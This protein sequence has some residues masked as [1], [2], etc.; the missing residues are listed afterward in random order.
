RGQRPHGTSARVLS[1]WEPVIVH[2][3][4]A[5]DPSRGPGQRIDSLVHGVVPMTTLPSRVTGTK[6]AAFCRWVFDLLGAQPGDTLHDLYP[7]SGAVTRAWI[8]YTHPPPQPA[9]TASEPPL[10]DA[11][12]RTRA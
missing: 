4:R 11:S 2:G 8:T 9:D 1:A 3:G 7:G 12:R 5:V 6:P 10:D